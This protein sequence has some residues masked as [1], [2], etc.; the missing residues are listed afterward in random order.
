MTVLMESALP[1]SLMQLLVLG[2]NESITFPLQERSLQNGNQ[3]CQCK[4]GQT[5]SEHHRHDNI[6]LGKLILPALLFLLT[7][8]RLLVWSCV[9]WHGQSTWEVDSLVGR[10]FSLE[11]LMKVYVSI[12][13]HYFSI[14]TGLNL[15]KIDK[16]L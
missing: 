14:P 11:A 12:T 8:G 4:H 10:G 16:P 5:S 15:V 2:S 13:L 6:Q 7:L 9:N 3:H 1:T